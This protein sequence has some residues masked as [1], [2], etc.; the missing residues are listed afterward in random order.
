MKTQKPPIE[1]ESEVSGSQL[2]TL[3]NVNEATVRGWKR[4]GMPA[5]AYNSRLYRY[6]LSEVQKWLDDRAAKNAV[7]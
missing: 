3:F 6:R 4:A 7:A 1:A 2:A 5:R